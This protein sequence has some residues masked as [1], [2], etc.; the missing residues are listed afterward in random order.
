[1]SCVLIECAMQ[2]LIVC[3]TLKGLFEL[4]IN[5]MSKNL[6]VVTINLN[7]KSEVFVIKIWWLL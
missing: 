3:F 5:D 6:V 1:M 2:M 4:S 7:I